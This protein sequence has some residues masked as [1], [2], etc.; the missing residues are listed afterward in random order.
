MSSDRMDRRWPALHRHR[1][2]P[3]PGRRGRSSRVPL[4]RRGTRSSEV[5]YAPPARTYT[6]PDVVPYAL[7]AAV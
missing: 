4:T 3:W 1:V 2:V 7:T 6:G 5:A